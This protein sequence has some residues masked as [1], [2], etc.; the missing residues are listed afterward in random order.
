MANKIRIADLAKPILSEVQKNAIAYGDTLKFDFTEN[1]VLSAARERTGLADF[2]PS[3]FL[4][5]L[6]LLLD[7]WS[8]DDQLTLSLIHI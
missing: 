2:G 5:R 4:E 1:G 3:D 8:S 6:N 7:E